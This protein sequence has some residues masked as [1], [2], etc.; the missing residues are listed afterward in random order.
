MAIPKCPVCKD[1]VSEPDGFE[2][3]TCLGCGF[4]YVA[5]PEDPD[6]LL[7]EQFVVIHDVQTGETEI[8]DLP[9]KKP[10]EDDSIPF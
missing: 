7:V 3:Y 2:G 6:W 4:T 10:D 9:I 5:Q 1:D 8:V